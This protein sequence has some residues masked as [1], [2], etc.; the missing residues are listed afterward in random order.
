M[1]TLVERLLRIFL[2]AQGSR[3]A[4]ARPTATVAVRV[5]EPLY[6]SAAR[7]VGVRLRGEDVALVRPYVV[8][9]ER[10]REREAQR[11]RRTAAALATCG[12]DYPHGHQGSA[13]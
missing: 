11:E 7:A 2:P 1:R 8:A 3:R 5:D 12:V 13:A 6:G 4:Q 10:Q 9:W